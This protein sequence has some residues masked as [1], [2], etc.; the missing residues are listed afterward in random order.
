MAISFV[1]DRERRCVRAVYSGVIAP[2][3]VERYAAALVQQRL[4]H[5]PQLIDARRALL[6]LSEA[7]V[8]NL[9]ALMAS[10]RQV[11][12]RA[13]VAFV[14]GNEASHDVAEQYA[15]LGAGDN[16]RFRIFDTLES[17]EGWFGELPP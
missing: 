8:R 2:Q 4:L 3:D 9:A 10:L 13:P 1:L 7:D 14:P 6:A 16:A 17:A 11:H 5:L 15:E 12:G